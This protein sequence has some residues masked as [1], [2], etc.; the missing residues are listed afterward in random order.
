[1]NP[2]ETH[3]LPNP[4]IGVIAVALTVLVFYLAFAKALP[5]TSGYEVRAVFKNA[6]NLALKSPVRI[7][8]VNIGKV[9]KIEPLAGG[10]GK[11]M[12][13]ALVTMRI[14][15][16]GRPIHTDAKMQL[17]PRLFLEGNLFVDTQPGSPSAPEAASGYTIPIQHTSNTVQ[18][19]QVLTSL[20]SGT[21]Q[22]LQTLLDELGSAFVDYG[23]AEGFREFYRTSA[24]ANR[25][26]A[27]VN[28]ALLGTAPNDLSNLVVNLDKTV[29]AL[30]HDPEQLKGLVTN[31]STVTGSFAAEDQA[32]QVAIHT[33]PQTL[34]A[35]R[36]ALAS[37]NQAF[38]PLRAFSRE[39]LPGTRSAGP[40]L[41][42]ANPWIVQLRGLVS[43]PELRGLVHDLRPT[44]PKLA[45]LAIASRPFLEQAR[46]L[47]SCFANV[48]T[49]WGDM[50]VQPSSN[51]TEPAAGKVYQETGYGLVGLAGES[52]SG[53]ANGPY[54]RVEA[55]GGQNTIIFPAGPAGSGVEKNVGV[56]PFPILGY[57][58]AI[59]A[60]AK[61]PFR[62]DIPCETQEPPDLGS[63]GPA[64]PPQQSQSNSRSS[65]LSSGNRA[66]ILSAVRTLTKSGRQ[67]RKLQARHGRGSKRSLKRLGKQMK[68]AWGSFINAGPSA[69]E[70]VYG[71]KR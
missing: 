18:L 57:E 42:A 33:L 2:R 55:G 48:I 67:E 46:S 47:S 64:A 29:N 43:K 6:Q 11:A 53:D 24:V 63:G 61:T 23:G 3:R 34:D 31:L 5:W 70:I 56:T 27:E 60:S 39:A 41:D 62:P 4:V 20:Q 50:Q 21:R 68:R 16:G 69:N 15:D 26:T 59:A 7:A 44:V 45:N 37:L 54:I 19:D 25:S 40:A 9:S 8:G 12:Q 22:D 14:D 1:M 51:A 17:R 66:T 38:P 30:N 65:T 52:R 49:P 36:P 58:P 32:L 28:Q 10:D 35:A 71:G 13:A